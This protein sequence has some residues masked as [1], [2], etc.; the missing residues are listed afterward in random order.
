MEFRVLKYWT[1]LFL[2]FVAFSCAKP[3]KVNIPGYIEKVVI[4]GSIETGS[5]P[6]VL[7][8]KNK[9]VY[10]PTT[11]Q[12]ALGGYLSGAKVWVSDGDTTIQLTEICT[13]NLP[14]GMDTAVANFLGVPVNILSQVTIC[15]YVGLDGNF[16][17]QVGKTYSLKVEFEGKVY[18]AS[19]TIVNPV[20]LT[21]SFWK[22]DQ[23]IANYGLLHHTLQDPPVERN[24][25]MYEV[26]RL[27]VDS[28]GQPKDKRFFKAFMCYFDDEFF[29]GISFEFFQDNPTTYEDKTI[30]EKYRGYFHKGDT[31]EVKFS[32]YEHRLFRFLNGIM[33]QKM[34]GGSPFSLP[35]NAEGNFSNGALGAWIAFSPSF[36]TT[37]CE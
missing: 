6:F 4:E 10:S 25:Y 33:Q 8:S 28:T 13:N 36:S 11:Q 20:N 22:E 27:N 34:A 21:N 15:A 12:E 1:G 17:G 16:I 31:I 26:K 23:K 30:D 2:M 35:T 5:F 3:V 18:E 7:I 19:S 14:N 32:A 9:N 24:A 37:V 29:N